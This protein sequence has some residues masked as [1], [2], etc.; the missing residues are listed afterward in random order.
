[1]QLKH[2]EEL[3]KR[4]KM[5]IN[6]EKKLIKEVSQV[7]SVTVVVVAFA[8]VPLRFWF[9]QGKEK[10]LSA[11]KTDFRQGFNKS[12]EMSV[13]TKFDKKVRR[14]KKKYLNLTGSM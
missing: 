3:G 9:K 4:L 6:T 13:A 7:K 10:R 14:F 11:R 2:Q 1:M 5:N 12:A 8:G